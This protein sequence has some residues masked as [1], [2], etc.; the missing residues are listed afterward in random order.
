MKK[1]CILCNSWV[2]FKDVMFCKFNK[3]ICDSCYDNHDK[4][5]VMLVLLDREVL[6]CN[7]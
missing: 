4:G 1:Y 2:D 6:R 7:Y 5:Y 3:C